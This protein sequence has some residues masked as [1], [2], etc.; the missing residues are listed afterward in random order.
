MAAPSERCILYHDKCASAA[1]GH[2]IR[3]PFHRIL[4][5]EQP[6]RRPTVF[7]IFRGYRA[8]DGRVLDACAQHACLGFDFFFR[9]GLDSATFVFVGAGGYFCCAGA[10]FYHLLHVYHPRVPTILFQ[11]ASA[12]VGRHDFVW[13]LRVLSAPLLAGLLSGRDW[14]RRWRDGAAC[15]PACAASATASDPQRSGHILET[16]RHASQTQIQQ[17]NVRR[18]ESIPDKCDA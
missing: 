7:A 14:A 13:M 1:L 3:G 15:G 2:A 11:Q 17:K 10:M 8:F 4:V 18:G 5:A 16:R 6:L 12:L 9:C